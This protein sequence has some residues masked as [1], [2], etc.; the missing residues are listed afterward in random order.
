MNTLT[1]RCILAV[2]LLAGAAAPQAEVAPGASVR[3]P[4]FDPTRSFEQLAQGMRRLDPVAESMRKATATI[5]PLLDE[6]R[7]NPSLENMAELE[8][9]VAGLTSEMARRIRGALA[10][11][12]TVTFAFQDIVRGVR[13]LQGTLVAKGGQLGRELELERRGLSSSTEALRAAAEAVEGA[14]DANERAIRMEAFKKLHAERLRHAMR[15]KLLETVSGNYAKLA[16]G[17]DQL[18]GGLLLVQ[19]R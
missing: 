18:A 13:E 11:R 7:A 12:E 6:Y 1:I 16:G 10:A 9:A 14:R 15:V 19:G 5:G 8:G 17:A 4:A 3:L 2:A